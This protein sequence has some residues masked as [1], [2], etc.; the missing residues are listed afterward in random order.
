MTSTSIWPT[1]LRSLPVPPTPSPQCRFTWSG[2]L[3]MF[4]ANRRTFG[5]GVSKLALQVSSR[6][7]AMA[8]KKAEHE[9]EE[10]VKLQREDDE[11][12]RR[13]AVLEA[14]LAEKDKQ[15]RAERATARELER[16]EQKEAKIRER[17]DRATLGRIVNQLAA[18]YPWFRNVR[19][20]VTKIEGYSN[21]FI[22]K[23]PVTEDMVQRIERRV[24]CNPVFLASLPRV[25]ESYPYFRILI[26]RGLSHVCRPQVTST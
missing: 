1:V 23:E 22:F 13:K 16:M 15:A 24:T 7:L 6:A 2:C 21:A 14:R 8:D 10:A 20:V 19:K 11:K 12:Q 3:M 18:E 26:S 25:K 9:A 4:R 17:E 5:C